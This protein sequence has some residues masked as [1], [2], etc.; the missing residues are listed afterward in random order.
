M[1]K[2]FYGFTTYPF[3][4]TPDPQ[5]L[6]RSKN[7]ENSLRYLS[8]SLERSHGLIVLKGKIGTGKTLLLNILVKSLDEKAH[9]AF[10][11]N[12][13]LDFL[14][15]LKYICRE[16]GLES[17]EKSKA[18]LLIDLENFLLMCE[19]TNEKAV[20]I[21]DEAQN[22][23]VDTLE[24]LRLLTNFENHERKL[25]QII[26][27]GQ[28]Q[29]EY[30]LKLP[31]LAQLSQR[32]AYDWQLLPMNYYETKAYVEKRLAIAGCTY[33]LFTSRA[34]KKIFA[35]SKGIPRVINII[36][37]TALLFAF[38]DEKRQIEH[39]VIQRV[40]KELNLYTPEKPLSY[41]ADQKR[42]EHRSHASGISSYRDA[43]PSAFSGSSRGSEGV[44]R[45]E[46]HQRPRNSGRP[47]RLA[48]IA[49][50]TSLSL[51]GAGLILQSSLT[52]GKRREYTANPVLISLPTV[53][54][55]P[56]RESPFLPQSP[57]VHELP[58]RVQWEQTTVSYQVLPGKPLTVS[59]PRLQRTP[60]DL[61]IKV[62]LDVSDS[63]PRWL[64]FDPEKLVLSGTPPP[65]ETGKT[66]LLR[67]R[68]RTADG[69]EI[70]LQ[71]VLAV[72][73]HTRQRKG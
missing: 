32:I 60:K 69:L 51:L 64:T 26:L 37:D 12:S 36:C 9:I 52:G 57:G 47:R 42:G 19:K 14:D 68:A 8:Y 43:T 53:L 46:Q 28:L 4:L 2:E 20:V 18:D 11:V 34:M 27:A 45:V 6:Y 24:E 30:I 41:Y 5:F 40:V 7:H 61:P 63:K 49:G 72:K 59:L 16:F 50:L 10:L 73:G 70:P 33:P 38:S 1:Y 23:S 66:Y 31:E 44:E 71:L 15:I 58:Y 54:P 39:T 13:K 55:L 29:L 17:T 62:T 25:L 3:S 48:L 35:A 65:Q 56:M 67:F 22:L 21:I